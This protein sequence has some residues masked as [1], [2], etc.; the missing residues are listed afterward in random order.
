MFIFRGGR[1]VWSESDICSR[2]PL[3][4]LGVWDRSRCGVVRVLL[5]LLRGSIATVACV[6]YIPSTR[7]VWG[8][9]PV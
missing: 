8:L 3:V 4:T 6:W 2:N 7:N 5:S 9:L 1:S